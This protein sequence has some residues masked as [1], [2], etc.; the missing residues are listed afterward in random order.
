[1]KAMEQIQM[2]RSPAFRPDINGI[3]SIS[4]QTIGEFA[5]KGD[6]LA[7]EIFRISGQYLGKGIA[8]LIDILNPEAIIIGS[9]F[10][11]QEELLLPPALEVIKNEALCVSS[12][13]CRIIKAGLGDKLGDA[14][15]LGVAAYSLEV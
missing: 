2:G 4:A 15:A 7:R 8:I 14:A 1:M 5:E 10:L 3:H 12:N 11:H 13:R 6:P 9:I